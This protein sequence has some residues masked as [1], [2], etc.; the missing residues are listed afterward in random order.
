MS[1]QEPPASS[2]KQPWEQCASYKPPD[3]GGT[4][5]CRNVDRQAVPLVRGRVRTRGW[6]LRTRRTAPLSARGYQGPGDNIAD[7]VNTEDIHYH[8]GTF[9][10][11]KTKD[12]ILLSELMVQRWT[13]NSLL[14]RKMAYQIANFDRREFFVFL[15]VRWLGHLGC[16]LVNMMISHS[17]VMKY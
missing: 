13:L 4:N 1:S 14:K 12:A 10:P 8:L 2:T 16:S 5:T 7:R 6:G 11:A 15:V 17:F 9:P 3:K